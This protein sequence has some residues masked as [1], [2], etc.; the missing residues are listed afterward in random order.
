MKMMS[1]PSVSNGLRFLFLTV[2]C[3][4]LVV[5]WDAT[6]ADAITQQK[7]SKDTVAT[8]RVI[9]KITAQ[10]ELMKVDVGSVVVYKTLEILA[11]RCV[12]SKSGERFAALLE[13]YENH[14]IEGAKRLFA[15]W[16][17]S[18]N[19][20]ISNLEHRYY[21]VGIVKCEPRKDD[22]EEKAAKEEKE[23]SAPSQEP[24]E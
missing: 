19:A 6:A 8:L 7:G 11:K 14:P 21:D 13:I 23:E 15:G 1:F 3:I 20:S 10:P 16:L 2:L 22:E 9:D 24:T 5:A 18:D 12:V 17:F 4:G